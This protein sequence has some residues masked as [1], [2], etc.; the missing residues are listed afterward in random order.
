[1][2]MLA[3]M[4]AACT[5]VRD[6]RRSWSGPRVGD[7]PLLDIGVLPTATATLE[8]TSIDTHGLTGTL[9]IPGVAIAASVQSLPS[10]EADAL[11]TLTFSG[12]PVRVFLAFVP[13]VDGYGDA[14]AFIALYEPARIEVRV[15][16][17]GVA[18]LYAI[19]ALTSGD[20]A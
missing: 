9:T 2:A 5:D 14:T 7:L 11:A 16:R 17:G 10:A 18:P 4:A 1:M 20:G 13:T 15:M 8:I 6:F 12:G 19:F 3:A